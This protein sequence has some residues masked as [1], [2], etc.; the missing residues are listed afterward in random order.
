M[1]AVEWVDRLDLHGK[2]GEQANSV[3][4]VLSP[5]WPHYLGAT[6]HI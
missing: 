2:E 3:D 1:D 4:Y 6:I 5:H